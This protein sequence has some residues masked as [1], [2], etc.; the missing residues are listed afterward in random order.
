MKLKRYKRLLAGVMVGALSV[1]ALTG[2]GAV[3]ETSPASVVEEATQ[4]VTTE[5]VAPEIV[6]GENNVKKE[7]AESETANSETSTATS[8]GATS[9]TTEAVEAETETDTAFVTDCGFDKDFNKVD[10]LTSDGAIKVL[11]KTSKAIQNKDYHSFVQYTNIGDIMRLSDD[12]NSRPLT[13]DEIIVRLESG[14]FDLEGLDGLDEYAQELKEAGEISAEDFEDCVRM[15]EAELSELNSFF[16]NDEL[17]A[18]TNF[19]P[20]YTDGWKLSP[21]MNEEVNSQYENA[22]MSGFLS[23]ISKLYVLKDTQ[24]EWKMDVGLH[25]VI[26]L[27]SMMA[28]S[29]SE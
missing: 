8:D 5:K 21:K 24:G 22:D 4:E 11:V 27:Y 13:D 12:K 26:I 1:T 19:K 10:E 14:G 29:A 15:T 20:H 25:Y 23:D 7:T 3:S 17:F 18:T 9:D 16:D 28:D 6:V 2:C